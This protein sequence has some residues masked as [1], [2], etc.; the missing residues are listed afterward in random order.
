M[1]LSLYFT[2]FFSIVLVPTQ[3]RSAPSVKHDIHLAEMPLA[4]ESNVGQYGPDVKFVARSAGATISL[5]KERATLLLNDVKR[6]VTITP[7]GITH[8]VHMEGLDETE[9]KSNY[10]LGDDP[11]KWVTNVARY[12]RVR[13]RNV[14]PGIDLIFHGNQRN[15]EY[16]FVIS[17][18]A[19]PNRI[20]LKFTGADSLKLDRTGDL[21]V[22]TAGDVSLT[23]RVPVLY[24]EENGVRKKVE[25]SYVIRGKDRIG[26]RVGA[27]VRSR[28]LV[29]DPVVGYSARFA[30]APGISPVAIAVDTSGNAYVTGGTEMFNVPAFPGSF[31]IGVESTTQDSVFVY[32]LNST[33]TDYVYTTLIGGS[34]LQYGTGIVVDGEG[35]VF[36]TGVTSSADFPVTPG[37]FQT[38]LP[39]SN[40]HGFVLKLNAA[41]NALVY[42]TFI[43]GNWPDS[44]AAIA[45]DAS[46]NAYITGSTESTTFPVTPGAFQSSLAPPT[47]GISVTNAFVTKLNSNGTALVYSTYL[48]GGS[49]DSGNG[50]A[51]DSDGNAYVAGSTSSSNFPVT[52]GAFQKVGGGNNGFATKMNPTGSSLVYSTFLNAGNGSFASGIAVDSAGSAYVAGTGSAALLG[53]PTLYGRGGIFVAKLNPAGSTLSYLTSVG[54]SDTQQSTGIALDSSNNVYVIGSSD[55]T[56]FPLLSPV[57]T[58]GPSAT[59]GFPVGVV[60]KL[61]PS[62]SLAYSTYFGSDYDLP[63]AIAVDPN[64]NA[65]ITGSAT[66]ALF[67]VTPGAV[68]VEPASPGPSDGVFI[69]QLSSSEVCNFTFSPTSSQEPASGA[70]DSISVTAPSGCN[71]IALAGQNWTFPSQP[72]VRPL[73]MPAITVTSPSAGS[74]SG[75][76]TFS[77]PPN[78]NPAR[79]QI[80]SIA[81]TS[82]PVSQADGCTY[83]LSKPS[84][85]VPASGGSFADAFTLTTGFY[86]PY[87]V[88]NP[89]AWVTGTGNGGTFMG[90]AT[91]D[92]LISANTSAAPRSVILTVAGL[93]FVINQAGGYTCT[94]SLSPTTLTVNYMGEVGSFD[95][96][97]V[98]GCSW[99][100][101]SDSA[102]LQIAGVSS[103][104]S[105]SS[106]VGTGNGTVSYRVLENI[107]SKRTGVITVGGK[108]F[109]VTEGGFAVLS[110]GPVTPNSGSGTSQTFALQYS[111]T[112]GAASLQQVWA[113]FNSTLANP[114]SNT[115]LLYYNIPTNQIN[116][117]GDNG[118]TWQ[119]AT[120]GAATTLQ[121]SQCSINVAT[122]TIVLGGNTLTLNLPMTFK[123]AFAG[124]KNIYL[125][126]VDGSGVDSGWEQLGT[127]VV[128]ASTGTASAISVT[129]ASGSGASQ[130]FALQYSDTAG[131][132]SLQQVWVYFNATLAN[133]ATNTCLLYYNIATNQ[134]NL[135]GDNGTTWQAAKLGTA[136]TLQ[137][138]QCSVSVATATVVSSGNTLT[139][140]LPMTF[141]P[142][143]AGVKNVYLSA[144][145]VSGT[146]STWQELGS[147]TVTAATGTPAAVSVTPNS[148]SGTSQSFALHYSDTAGAA[149]LRQ[150]WAYFNATLAN[151]ASSAC[152]LYYNAATNQIS[153]LGDNGSTW[154]AATLGTGTTLEN[155]QCSVS[156]ATAT[157]I[158]NGNSLT[159]NV[160]MTFQPAYDGTKNIYLQA[161]DSSGTTS[162]WQPLGT[163]T[164]ASNGGTPSAVSVTPNSGSGATQTFAL[165]YSD[166]A[167]A[168][169]L[170]QVWAYFNATL[171]NPASN[172][173]LLYYN[174]ATNQ[175]NLLGDDGSTWQAATIEAGTTLQNTQCAVNV[176]SVT[177]ALNG[178]ALTWTMTMSF[179]VP[180]DGT[181][182]I[183]LQAIDTS[184]TTSGWQK[185]GN[186]IVGPDGG[187]PSTVSVTPN[188]GSG[189]TQTF[190]LQY[191]DT[192]GAGVLQQVWAYF[193]ATLANPASNACLVYYNASTNQI[194]LLGDNGSTWQAA[195]L[196]TATTLENSQC[197]VNA[198]TMTVVFNG[199]ILTWNVAMTFQ[200]AYDGAKNI[201]LRALDVSGSDSS[202][203]QL[204][205]WSVP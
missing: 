25:G 20:E 24:Q 49:T 8:S 133:P 95:V 166:T 130:T 186:W 117:L 4:F 102:W 6:R 127:W 55:A 19:D 185:L 15:I 170:Q 165:Q 47:M 195:T 157:V 54:G 177:V 100:L 128:A 23:Q 174:S 159:W 69:A 149:S 140:N 139:L 125:H 123:P 73:A 160:P 193:N 64:S 202:W 18:G 16:D 145:D 156:V 57:Q 162:G 91:F 121:N 58:A 98:P 5:N 43:G 68:D 39:T 126:A 60:F 190:A 83:Q 200:P 44:P 138:S 11:A 34:T 191:S 101:S 164:V 158:S 175:I 143:Y 112:A 153:L 94:Y 106:T 93:P 189:A 72:G 76:V 178:N 97:T 124:A 36:V 194:N 87:T 147:W 33:G 150:V 168:G 188:S 21:I 122:A 161:I 107:S 28:T 75:V 1:S 45:I 2:V 120:L 167:G 29:I 65:Y 70:T 51:V 134:I 59:D 148:G 81:G 180:Y 92:L 66:S 187:T 163:W 119:A 141:K 17:P 67:P 108:T 183:Y 172:A 53:T 48:G 99:T 26:F 205:A 199:N 89:A 30:D 9:G 14:Y 80:L 105:S 203:Q 12:S 84:I 176:S 40:R 201:Y 137:N 22:A 52:N 111:D 77:I 27:Y 197:S 63:I 114:A 131:A 116:L 110:S 32:K 169:K 182:N 115:C 103:S 85:M 35:N 42:S 118:T 192:A 82:I 155:S 152:L 10:L 62:G 78:T 37:A 129:P 38:T 90:S 154:Q 132:A 7:V 88:S 31:E 86:C 151:P 204:G 96:S 104:Y 144:V 41:G 74:G 181:K 198:A 61:D 136:V 142:L 109:T 56:D 171:A 71:W 135:L 13:Y 179:H 3:I 113:Y 79:T 196:G 173:C 46:G 146:S 50:I 184:G